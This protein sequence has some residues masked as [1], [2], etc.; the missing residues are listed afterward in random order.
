MTKKDIIEIAL[1]IFGLYLLFGAVDY[2]V[3][4]TK[5]IGDIFAPDKDDKTVAIYLSARAFGL[6]IYAIGSYLL[7]LKT[8]KVINRLKIKDTNRDT[9]WNID[10]DNLL[11]ILFATAGIIIIV[12]SIPDF[13]RLLSFIDTSTLGD[14]FYKYFY[15][16]N[17][18]IPLVKFIIGAMLLLG[19]LRIIKIKKKLTTL[20]LTYNLT[21]AGLIILVIGAV[22]LIFWLLLLGL[23]LK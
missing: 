22:V 9:T 20:G 3:G 8:D 10:K 5:S 13:F 23:G 16:L 15:F 18:L 21:N 11:E 6:T 14:K 19:A 12:F 2:F 17:L 7:T 1:K 4:L